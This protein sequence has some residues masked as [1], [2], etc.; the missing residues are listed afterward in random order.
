MWRRQDFMQ[1]LHI[2]E[3]HLFSPALPV[4]YNKIG[5]I[6]A[7]SLLTQWLIWQMK[8]CFLPAKHVIGHCCLSVP[9]VYFTTQRVV[10]LYSIE[11]WYGRWKVNYR[12]WDNIVTIQEFVRTEWKTSVRLGRISPVFHWILSFIYCSQESAVRLHVLPDESNRDL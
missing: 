4:S 9:V 6:I 8:A 7:R 1:C 3:S 10:A 2:K 5:C 11:W 12:S